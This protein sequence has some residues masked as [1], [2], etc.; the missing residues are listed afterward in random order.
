MLVED[1]ASEPYIILLWYISNHNC[2]AIS[3]YNP[4][5]SSV[6]ICLS[7]AFLAK[8]DPISYYQP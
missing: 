6:V 8:D 4:I 1:R 3:I 2:Y 5:L 7:V